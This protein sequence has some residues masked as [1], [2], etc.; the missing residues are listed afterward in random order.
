MATRPTQSPVRTPALAALTGAAFALYLFVADMVIPPPSHAQGHY[1]IGNALVG[2]LFFSY[3]PFT[4]ALSPLV[5]MAM[6][7][8]YAYMAL[9]RR[10]C[11][12]LALLALHY[13][14]AA[15]VAAPIYLHRSP[16]LIADTR[17]QFIRLAAQPVTALFAFAPFIIANV[18]YVLRMLS[19]PTSSA[20]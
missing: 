9:A 12:G 3:A 15:L 6:Y 1:N 18:W 11:A 14:V 7:G 5:A 4:A 20:T 8:T 13:G 10:R 17:D 2:A 19:Q 16:G